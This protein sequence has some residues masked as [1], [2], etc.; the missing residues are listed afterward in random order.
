VCAATLSY[1]LRQ[2]PPLFGN[3]AGAHAGAIRVWSSRQ[4][5]A[6]AN[7][8]EYVDGDDRRVECDGAEG[9]DKMQALDEGG[10]GNREQHEL[11]LN[12]C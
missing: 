8:P 5:K 3:R 10:A 11:C 12:T 7:A 1:A 9:G 2:V 6:G 4:L